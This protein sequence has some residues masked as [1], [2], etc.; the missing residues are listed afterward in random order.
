MK[1][2]LV[3]LET[4]DDRIRRDNIKVTI[5]NDNREKEEVRL[6]DFF[7]YK[8][9]PWYKEAWDWLCIYTETV[10][11]FLT[12]YMPKYFKTMF[13]W[14][15]EM[16]H[17]DYWNN[18]SILCME[19]KWCKGALQYHIDHP[20]FVGQEYVIRDLKLAISLLEKVINDDESPDTLINLTNA[21]RF[22]HPSLYERYKDETEGI[23]SYKH[24]VRRNKLW[25]V[26]SKLRFYRFE[27]WTD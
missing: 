12:L 26:Y 15:R 23:W 16:Y 27:Y 24:A 13:N 2:E 4:E 5:I 8:K 17:M 7:T 3:K 22:V 20:R 14:S 25:H 9:D 11:N 18:Y 19:L 1:R 21:Y 10:W 6:K